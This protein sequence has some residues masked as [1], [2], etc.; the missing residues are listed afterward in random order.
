MGGPNP[1]LPDYY[2]Q[3]PGNGP[4]SQASPVPGYPPFAQQQQR[5]PMMPRPPFNGQRPGF[6]DPRAMQMQQNNG[7]RMGFPMGPRGMAP[8]YQRYMDSPST[9]TFPPVC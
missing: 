8:S 4:S 3:N 6:V 9:P 1:S 5:F 2:G 7:Q